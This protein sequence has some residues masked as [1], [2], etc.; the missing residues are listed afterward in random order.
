MKNRMPTN[1]INV[2]GS[3]PNGLVAAIELQKAGFEV[4]IFEAKSTIG[5]GMR[6]DE[7]TLPGL[8]HDICS[9][10]HPT[11][12][13]SPVFN[14]YPLEQY[15]LEWIFP[16][17]CAAHPFDDGT[18][19][20]LFKD[21]EKTS[22]TLGE[23]AEKYISLFTHISQLVGKM[24]DDILAPLKIP[25]HSLDFVQFGLNAILPANWFSKRFKT[26]EAKGLWAGMSAHSM[27][28][29]NQPATSAIALVLMSA[30]HLKGWPLAKSGSQSIAD[31]LAAYFISLGGKI[32]TNQPI[33]SKKDLP[34]ASANVFDLTPRQILEI[35]KEEIGGFHRKTL[36]NFRYGMGIFKLDWAI[37][38]VVPFENEFARKAGTVHLGGTFEEIAISEHAAT[39]GIHAQ[40]PFVLLVQQSQ[41]DNTRTVD[42][43]NTLYAYCHVPHGSTVDMTETIESQIERFA[44]GFKSKIVARNKMNSIEM[45]AYNS[46]YIGGDIGGGVIDL[47]QLYTRPIISFDP[48]K[49]SK[50]GIFICSSSTPPGGGVHGMCGYHAAKSVMKYLKIARNV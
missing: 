11:A 25:N 18:A 34:D 30:G 39:N 6:T 26:K 4:S 33:S 10:I 50:K 17:V 16:E 42:S 27:L 44:P 1:N 23:D 47:Q 43:L 32:F 38:G 35:V 3:G 41:F 37:D 20:A 19:A 12:Q 7:L 9:A 15:G 36:Q 8:R 2:I 29:L 45:Q 24:P 14:S 48:Y 49:L 46:N 21:I 13:I 5:G 28:P 40:K 22:T 31:A